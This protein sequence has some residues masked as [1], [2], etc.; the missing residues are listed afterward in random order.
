[1]IAISHYRLQALNAPLHLLLNTNS[2]SRKKLNTLLLLQSIK[3]VNTCLLLVLP[4]LP[5]LFNHY[6]STQLNHPHLHGRF[7][8]DLHPLCSSRR[9]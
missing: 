8:L 4:E 9:C 1:M 5:K 6:E 7:G 2:V 3:L